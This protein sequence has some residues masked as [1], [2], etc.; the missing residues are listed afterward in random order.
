MLSTGRLSFN[1]LS[2]LTPLAASAAARAKHT[3]P[4]LPYDYEALNPIICTEIMQLHHSKHH[5]TYV[6]NLNIAEEKYAEA[7]SKG[8]LKTCHTSDM[9]YGKHC[10]LKVVKDREDRT[11]VLQ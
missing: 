7:Q 1:L 9:A 4:E 2:R 10:Y 3:L 8:M 5:A 11:R 6:N